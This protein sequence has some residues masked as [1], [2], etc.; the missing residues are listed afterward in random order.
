MPP[1]TVMVLYHS[2]IT[3]A[4]LPYRILYY[5]F[6]ITITLLSMLW[7][8]RVGLILLPYFIQVIIW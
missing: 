5:P 6:T 8:V 3:I 4:M 7:L 2:I 1:V